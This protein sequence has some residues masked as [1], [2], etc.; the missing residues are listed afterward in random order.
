MIQL[1]YIPG[2][3]LLVAALFFFAKAYVD[4]FW[5]SGLGWIA[6][7]F[8]VIICLIPVFFSVDQ[9]EKRQE[10]NAALC[11]SLGGYYGDKTCYI[12]GEGVRFGEEGQN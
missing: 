2:V 10:Q 3:L 12:D 6:L 8:A 1:F 11:R 7:L 9:Y 5:W 4:D